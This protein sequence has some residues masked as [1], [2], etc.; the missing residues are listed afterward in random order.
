MLF[1]LHFRAWFSVIWCVRV[2]LKTKSC[3]EETSH[4]DRNKWWWY[5]QKEKIEMNKN[6][7]KQIHV[8]S[9]LTITSINR[10]HVL[11]VYFKIIID[12]SMLVKRLIHIVIWNATESFHFYVKNSYLYHLGLIK[13]QSSTSSAMISI[14]WTWTWILYTMYSYFVWLS[15]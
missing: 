14:N 6:L 10:L 13:S 4:P 5:C 7:I 9:I 15:L 2:A 8:I 1:N 11:F 12:D 3:R